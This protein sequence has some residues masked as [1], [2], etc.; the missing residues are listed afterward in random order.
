MKFRMRKLFSKVY[1]AGEQVYRSGRLARFLSAVTGVSFP[2][3]VRPLRTTVR[4]LILTTFLMVAGTWWGIA[5]K[6]KTVWIFQEGTILTYLSVCMLLG[7]A[8]I[9]HRTW[10]ERCPQRKFAWSDPGSLWK[11]MSW[12]FFYLAL[13][14]LLRIHETFDR[15]VHKIAGVDSKG[16]T[17][18][19]DDVLVVVYGIIGMY[20][21]FRYRRESWTFL[22]R[23]PLFWCA[24]LTAVLHSAFEFLALAKYSFASRGWL[25]SK[26][27][28]DAF[29]DW[30][31][32]LEETAKTYSAVFFVGGFLGAYVL[33]RK[34]RISRSLSRAAAAPRTTPASPAR[35]FETD[36][37]SR[38]YN[39]KRVAHE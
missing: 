27:E 18:A 14:D 30:T 39:E 11:L 15:V 26:A 19:L 29:V 35:N 33:A 3:S 32:V 25:T 28:I 34:E 17:G 20:F 31:M 8:E 21:L 10:L 6:H 12:G 4:L 22:V 38:S 24:G 16:I 9:S 7:I 37:P 2:D 23:S 1:T 13:D 36:T 5:V